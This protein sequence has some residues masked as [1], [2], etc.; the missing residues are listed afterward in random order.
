MLLRAGSLGGAADVRAGTGV[1][2]DRA[3]PDPKLE[4]TGQRRAIDPP[5]AGR[6]RARRTKTPRRSRGFGGRRLASRTHPGPRLRLRGRARPGTHA[7]RWGAALHYYPNDDL[8]VAVLVNTESEAE[9]DIAEKLARTV[10]ESAS[11]DLRR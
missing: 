5:T 9:S 1:A 7:R 3:C 4:S 11:K 2:S 10:F 6:T 8:C